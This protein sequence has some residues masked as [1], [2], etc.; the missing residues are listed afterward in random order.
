MPPAFRSANT[1]GVGAPPGVHPSSS[2]VMSPGLPTSTGPPGL[3]PSFGPGVASPWAG[4]STPQYVGAPSVFSGVGFLSVMYQTTRPDWD[5]DVATKQVPSGSVVTS[6]VPG[7][8][9][10]FSP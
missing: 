1:V 8:P 5:R 4:M 3:L 10:F 2:P 7:F 9:I 6:S